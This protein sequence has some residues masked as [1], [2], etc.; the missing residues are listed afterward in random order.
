MLST[1]G[2]HP[3]DLALRLYGAAAT[4]VVGAMAAIRRLRTAG[5]DAERASLR[6]RLGDCELPPPSGRRIVIHAVS[7]GEMVAAG[8][9]L[10]A[11]PEALDGAWSVVLTTGTPEGRA[12]A[13]RLRARHA[14]VE[15]CLW[16]P[17][18]RPAIGRWIARL[19]PALL[20][21]VETEIWPSL[22]HAAAAAR[23]PLL[24]ASGRLY[25]RDVARYRLA[26]GF[27]SRVLGCAWR[28]AVQS[29][30]QRAAF[31]SI[32]A[33]PERTVVLG[34]LKH[35][36]AADPLPEPWASAVAGAPVLLG[37][38]THPGEEEMVLAAWPALRASTPGLRLVLVPRHP[39]RA[40]AIRGL[41]E[42]S[43]VSDAIVVDV[44]GVLPAWYGVARAAFIGGSLVPRGGH[45]PLEAAAQGC[46]AVLGPHVAHFR[47]EVRGLQQGGALQV[48]GGPGE[49]EGALRGILSD[50]GRRAAMSGAGRT[51]LGEGHGAARRHALAVAEALAGSQ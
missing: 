14:R 8:A 9:L 3:P 42:R 40:A 51:W 25:P 5:G 35:D 21:V 32:G 34:N 4:V 49:L 27:F 24:V 11:L 31:L 39:G 12:I 13:E 36:A 37:A 15:A 30:E 41:C 23:V 43:G 47:D 17:W 2:V 45:N 28:I 6:Q 48:V 29:E 38:S 19:S 20:V 46:P 22:F 33:E 50:G 44:M 7:A 1:P 10:D 18:D 26:R 16:L